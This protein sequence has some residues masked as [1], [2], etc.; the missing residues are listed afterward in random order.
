MKTCIKCNQELEESN[1]YTK[2]GKNKDKGYQ[3]KCKI[4]FNDNTKLYNIQNNIQIKKYLNN[5]YIN[6]KE[7]IDTANINNYLQED[8]I[9]LI[10]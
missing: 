2:G 6:N 8:K 10:Q 3:S 1:F 5:Y 7:K 9:H 4:C